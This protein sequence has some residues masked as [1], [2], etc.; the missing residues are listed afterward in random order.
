MGVAHR[1]SAAGGAPALLRANLPRFQWSIVTPG[2]LRRSGCAAGQN[3]ATH[4]AL[5]KSQRTCHCSDWKACAAHR[6][7]VRMNRRPRQRGERPISRYAKLAHDKAH[8]I[9]KMYHNFLSALCAL[10][11]L[12][13]ASTTTSILPT[14][15]RPRSFWAAAARLLAVGGPE[16]AHAPLLIREHAAEGSA[17]VMVQLQHLPGSN[18]S[19]LGAETWAGST[20]ALKNKEVRRLV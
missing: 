7:S 9:C 8:C 13:G 12:L 2:C 11:M 5:Q 3:S 4:G 16:R 20:A 15:Q 17:E 6:A 14:A 19:T 10:S 1:S 18:S